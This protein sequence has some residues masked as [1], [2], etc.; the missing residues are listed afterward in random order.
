MTS[1]HSEVDRVW[2]AIVGLV[3][4]TRGDWRRNVSEATGLPFTRVRALKRLAGGPLTLRAL[5]EALGTDA[6][7]ATVAVND[8]ERRGMVTRCEH[9]DDR[10][11][12]LVSL[13][14]AGKAALRAVK[15]VRDHAPEPLAS[16]SREDVK[17]L[18]RIFDAAAAAEGSARKARGSRGT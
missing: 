6:P 3:M 10:R 12:K 9:P 17:M 18:A 2:Q 4:D 13:T 8:L 5:A 15:S 1:E 16:M 11:A 7:A 14:A